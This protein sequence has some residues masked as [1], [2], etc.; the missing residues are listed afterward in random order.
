MIIIII[1]KIILNFVDSEYLLT[2]LLQIQ[3]NCQNDNKNLKILRL[4]QRCS[5]KNK[6]VTVKTKKVKEIKIPQSKLKC[7]PKQIC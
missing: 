6:N 3:K 1:I 7:K 5:W 2:N 4:K